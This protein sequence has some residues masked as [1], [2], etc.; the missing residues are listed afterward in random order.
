MLL[1]LCQFLILAAAG[2]LPQESS[3]ADQKLHAE[4]RQ[5]LALPAAEQDLIRLVQ[6]DLSLS[7]EKDPASL[8]TCRTILRTLAVSENE[9]APLTR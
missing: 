9:T 2:L 4:A 8:E 5:I 1:Q 6:I 7:D 3:D